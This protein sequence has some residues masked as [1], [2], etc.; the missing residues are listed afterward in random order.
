MGTATSSVTPD[1][2]VRVGVHCGPVV[3]GVVG[4]QKYQYD[5]WGDTVNVAARMADAGRPGTV[6]MT[7]DAWL[8]VDDTCKARRIGSVSVKGKGS[9]DVVECYALID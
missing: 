8:S 9:L 3:A 5:V 6:A 4:D 2:S 7:H 1:W